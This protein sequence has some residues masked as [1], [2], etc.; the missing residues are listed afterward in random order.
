MFMS[1]GTLIGI[2]LLLLNI[3]IV[4]T[5]DSKAPYFEKSIESQVHSRLQVQLIYIKSIAAGS[6][7]PVLPFIILI[8][9]Y[10]PKIEY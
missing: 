10:M 8:N 6:I 3:I 1:M 9:R 5:I 2:F 7:W 4:Q